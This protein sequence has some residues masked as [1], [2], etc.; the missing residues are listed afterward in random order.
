MEPYDGSQDRKRDVG[1][2]AEIWNRTLSLRVT[3]LQSN[4]YHKARTNM[5]LLVAY[6]DSEVSMSTLDILLSVRER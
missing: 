1:D 6:A 3:E 2:N 5:R 4:Y